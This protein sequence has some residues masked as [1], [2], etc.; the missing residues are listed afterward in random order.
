[1]DSS[2][3]SS[4]LGGTGYLLVRAG[5]ALGAIPVPGATV[6]VRE[7]L[8]NPE[9]NMR[10][11]II[12]VVVTDRDGRTER[13]PLPAPPRSDSMSP[14]G[15]LPYASYNID[16]EATGYYRQTFSDVPIFDAV[17]SIQPALLIPIAQNGNQDG[18]ST[19]ENN[20]EES[21]NPALRQRT[22][23]R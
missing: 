9:E 20:F 16:V 14:N 8:S 13:V 18:V 1:M 11:T 23:N 7:H 10:G 21:V 5:T 15:K 4:I 6:T 17:T 22:N 12:R 3:Q 2:E 19:N